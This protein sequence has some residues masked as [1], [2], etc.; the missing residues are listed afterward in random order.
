[1]GAKRSSCAICSCGC[2]FA[3]TVASSTSTAIDQAVTEA[4]ARRFLLQ[5]FGGDVRDVAT[6]A[7]QG[8]WS[9][10]FTFERGGT[11]YV[12]RFSEFREDFD[13]DRFAS[14]IVSSRIPIPR[15]IEI[16]EALG[17]FYA[18]TERSSGRYLDELEED[19]MRRAIPALFSVLDAIRR[20]T[21]PHDAG[22]GVW[23]G[24]GQAPHATWREALLDVAVDRP[25][26]L[27]PSRRG[28]LAASPIGTS[29]FDEV[30]E[31]MASLVGRCPE[32]RH[33]VHADL[34]NFNILV[35]EDHVSAVL[36]WGSSMFG[37]FLFDL[38]WLSFWWP[39]YPNWSRIDVASEAARHYAS[40]GLA[41][42]AFGKRLRCYELHIGLDGMLYSAGRR[43]WAHL[44]GTTRRALDL[45]RGP[46][47]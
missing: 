11:A 26:R 13:K 14:S 27:G 37:D 16:G 2:G 35:A 6:I 45:A 46:L 31:R 23:S 15:V 20:V 8:E 36:D 42:P 19:A 18:I 7:R 32:D 25:T 24:E 38:A 10:A 39:W 33:L 21:V 22:Y 5:R 12:I 29:A 44:E 41:V 9:R 3:A 43:D 28:A 4:D 30:F 40:I 47:P 17:G 1:L 34:L